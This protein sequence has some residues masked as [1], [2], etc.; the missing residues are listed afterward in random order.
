MDVVGPAQSKATCKLGLAYAFYQQVPALL[1]AQGA[2]STGGPPCTVYET[3]S[4]RG[5][6]E[7]RR[8]CI[9]SALLAVG[10]KGRIKGSFPPQFHGAT[11]LCFPK[12]PFKKKKLVVKDTYHE[13]DHFNHFQMHRS[14]AFSTFTMGCDRHCWLLPEPQFYFSELLRDAALEQREKCVV[15]LE[16]E[17]NKQLLICFVPAWE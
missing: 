10:P 2:G 5:P 3:R 4:A 17:M 16:S 9:L 1:R 12:P 15:L 11:I 7:C 8:A 6:S 14:V 13:M